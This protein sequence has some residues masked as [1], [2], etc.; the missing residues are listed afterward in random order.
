MFWYTVKVSNEILTQSHLIFKD[1]TEFKQIKAALVKSAGDS[2][3]PNLKAIT[4]I[5]LLIRYSLSP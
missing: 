1:T 3:S 4:N 2:A 5:L